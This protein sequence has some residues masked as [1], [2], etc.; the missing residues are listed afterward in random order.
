MAGR[1]CLAGLG[2]IT[3][4][5]ETDRLLDRLMRINLAASHKQRHAKPRQT[6]PH[7]DFHEFWRRD[8]VFS[9][10]HVKYRPAPSAAISKPIT[11]C[12]TAFPASTL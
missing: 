4:L 12:P 5:R 1:L 2:A 11:A 7:D 6:S 9:L 3:T 10:H 8:R